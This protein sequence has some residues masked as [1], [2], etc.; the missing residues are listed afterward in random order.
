MAFV[1]I[2]LSSLN[3]PKSIFGATLG[4]LF[5]KVILPVAVDCKHSVK[6]SE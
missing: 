2:A 4:S 6:K 5:F 3:N 1:Y